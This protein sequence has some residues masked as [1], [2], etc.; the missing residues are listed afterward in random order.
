MILTPE[1][2]TKPYCMNLI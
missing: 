2:M 1:C